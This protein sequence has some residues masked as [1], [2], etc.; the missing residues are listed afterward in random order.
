YTNMSKDK[1]DIEADMKAPLDRGED[2]AAMEPLQVSDGA[3]RREALTELAVEL[4]AKSAGFS[5]SLPAGAVSALADLVRAMN[6]YY[7]NLIE[8]HD[9]HPVD[10]ERAMQNDYSDEPRK[11]DLQL[12]A[13]AHVTVQ[14]W[15]DE[16]GVAGRATTMEGICEIHR[17]FGEALPDELLW[18]EDPQSG[19]RMRMTPGELRGRDVIVGDHVAISPGALPRFL[20][21]FEQVYIRLGNAQTIVSAAAAHHRFLWIHPFLDGNGRVARLMSYAMLREALDTGGIWSIARGLA[22]QEARY[23]QHLVACDLPRRG[24]LDGRGSRS[25]AALAEFTEFFLRTCIDQVAFMEQLVQPNKLRERI[26]LWVEEEVR[27]DGLPPQAGNVLEA[28][29]YRG[30]L[31]RG[32]VPGIVGTGDRQARRI[33]SALLQ[34]GVLQSASPR[35]PLQIAFPARLAGRWMPGLFPEAAN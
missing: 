26:R 34:M 2:T 4:A 8:G 33:V 30:E 35:T 13:R 24:D 7:S 21:R 22:R 11:R 12:E 25:E 10:I 3:P 20:R 23:K 17:R 6:C 19:E 14:Q 9:T 28:V 15:I 16:G 27:T 5:R 29:L 32:D 18:V 1:A 31:P